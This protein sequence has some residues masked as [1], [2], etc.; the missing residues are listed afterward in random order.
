MAQKSSAAETSTK[1][2]T[3]SVGEEKQRAIE[4]AQLQIEK[5]FGKGAVMRMGADDPARDVDVVSTGSLALDVALGIGGLPKGRVIEIYGP[6]S[7]GKTTLCLH[8]VAE[9]QKAGFKKAT[10]CPE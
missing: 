1:L 3:S 10:N 9:A 4:A 7:S 8:I 5:Q 6:E 2:A